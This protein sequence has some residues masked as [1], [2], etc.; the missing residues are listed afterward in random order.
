M[1]TTT[2]TQV[3]T[4]FGHALADPTRTLLL[5]ALRERPGYPSELAVG[6]SD[7]LLSHLIG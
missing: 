3:L 7:S 5:L 2:Q 1:E 6:G 4:R